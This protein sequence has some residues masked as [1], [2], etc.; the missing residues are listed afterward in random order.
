MRVRSSA[1]EPSSFRAFEA[2]T[3]RPRRTPSSAL[4][5]LR[6]L[7]T[8]R[9]ARPRPA[10]ALARRALSPSGATRTALRS[11]SVQQALGM[12]GRAARPRELPIRARIPRRLPRA[13]SSVVE[14]ATSSRDRVAKGCP[15]GALGRHR[16]NRTRRTLASGRACGFLR[17]RRR[18]ARRS[19]VRW[20]RRTLAR[21]S[22]TPPA[23]ARRLASR[24]SSIPKAS[25]LGSSASAK[26][27]ASRISSWFAGGFVGGA[28]RHSTP[29]VTA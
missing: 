2:S 19:D 13:P 18:R 22:S 11:C 24:M 26:S 16:L 14:R 27:L 23:G 5:Q 7:R 10:S 17:A 4:S 6:G 3:W 28:T 9:R 20:P 8:S 15:C 21:Y 12:P 1:T 25:L 29:I